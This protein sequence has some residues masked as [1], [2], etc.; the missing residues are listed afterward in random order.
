MGEVFPLAGGL[1][2]LPID[3]GR[4]NVFSMQWYPSR[5]A[6]PLFFVQLPYSCYVLSDTM[7]TVLNAY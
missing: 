3:T 5:H 6:H 4:Q 2:P 7:L 1:D